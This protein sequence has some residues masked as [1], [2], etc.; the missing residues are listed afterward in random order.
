MLEGV[1]AVLDGYG[2]A[3]R[4]ADVV[5]QPRGAGEVL[6]RMVAAR[7]GEADRALWRGTVVEPLPLVLGWEGS[8]V[9]EAIGDGVGALRA[10][11]HVVVMADD[12][13]AGGRGATAHARPLGTYATYVTLPAQ[14][15]VR[16]HPRLPL[17]VA[18]EA[19]G[20][21]LAGYGAVARGSPKIIGASVL[22]LELGDVG[23]AVLAAALAWSTARVIAVDSRPERLAWANSLGAEAI[24]AAHAALA[25][26]LRQATGG[27]GADCAFVTGARGPAAAAT[28]L[29]LVRTGGTVVAVPQ[30]PVGAD[31]LAALIERFARDRF[32]V[33]A[34]AGADGDLED[35]SELLAGAGEGGVPAP[36]V[37][38][39]FDMP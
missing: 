8:G 34:L 38:L 13:R 3:V 10:G 29:D 28:V 21:T 30:Q 33:R 37:R 36:L 9:V 20:A 39:S 26:A 22:V 16:I 27:T 5:A 23:Q 25:R 12:A 19:G 14:Q 1:A 18:A 7:V 15:A 31:D 35:L 32:A 17:R 24:P 2:Q 4:L 6:V 11:D